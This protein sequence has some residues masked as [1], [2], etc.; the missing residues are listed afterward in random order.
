MRPETRVLAV[1]HAGSTNSMPKETH[2]CGLFDILQWYISTDLSGFNISPW[3]L[4]NY[5]YTCRTVNIKLRTPI[6]IKY[7]VSCHKYHTIILWYFLR[8]LK[9]L[10]F[11]SYTC[12]ETTYS[13]VHTLQRFVL[14]CKHIHNVISKRQ[15]AAPLFQSPPP[16]FLPIFPGCPDHSVGLQ[17]R[18]TFPILFLR[19]EEAVH[20]ESMWLLPPQ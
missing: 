9:R 3:H 2:P 8:E 10:N 17:P 12:A 5:D 15:L 16:P 13:T 19:P 4:G 18:L 14:C 20:V 11:F 1:W 7:T 6:K